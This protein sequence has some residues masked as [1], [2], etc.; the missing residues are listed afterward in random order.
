MK[1]L[2]F[3]LLA[4][5]V[6]ALWG[7][8]LSTTPTSTPTSNI[9]QNFAPQFIAAVEPVDPFSVGAARQSAEH[10]Q[11]ISIEGR[12]GGTPQPFVNGLAAFTMVDFSIPDCC[13][14]EC[15][16]P[17]CS[18]AELAQNIV[19]VKFVDQNKKTLT[20]DARELLNLK[21]KDAVVIDG[22]VQRDQHGNFTVL[23]N[24]IFIRPNQ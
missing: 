12:I 10:D 6:V 7:C 18:P 1:K 19:T 4:T 17:E 9:S 2:F 14:A 24:K 8:N 15:T 13:G 21:E 3:L 23:A 20:V 11:A 22:L 5:G 16:T